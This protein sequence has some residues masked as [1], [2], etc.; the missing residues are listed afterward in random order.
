MEV[1]KSWDGDII[2][3][4]IFCIAN[5]KQ[6]PLPKHY[7]KV[8]GYKQRSFPRETSISKPLTFHGP[9]RGQF[10]R[11]ISCSTFA[12]SKVMRQRFSP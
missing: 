6:Y 12:G 11:K 9:R 5:L 1:T 3:V 10:H 7:R 4:V 2:S 8:E